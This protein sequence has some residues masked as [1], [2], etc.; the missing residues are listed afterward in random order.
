[1]RVDV[2][3]ESNCCLRSR[4]YKFCARRLRRVITKSI[5]NHSTTNIIAIM[6]YNKV[7]LY[8]GAMT[9]DLPSNFADVR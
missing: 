5:L 9:V 2:C 6:S 7:E 4:D 3:L 1:M 8:G